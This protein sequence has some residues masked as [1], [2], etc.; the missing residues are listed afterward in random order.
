M[1][2]YAGHETTVQP[3]SITTTLPV[4]YTTQNGPGSTTGTATG[5]T[6]AQWYNSNGELEWQ[7]DANGY[8]TYY[9]Y[10][11]VSGVLLETIQNVNSNT[12]LPAGFFRPRAGSSRPQTV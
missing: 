2:V 9:G 6:T 5:A 8:L 11:S 10:D 4:I 1:Y 3:E 12:S 7:Q